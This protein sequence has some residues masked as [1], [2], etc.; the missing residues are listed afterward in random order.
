M[1]SIIRRITLIGTIF[2]SLS[3][4]GWPD[5]SAAVVSA[6]YTRSTPIKVAPGQIDI[7]PEW[8]RRWPNEGSSG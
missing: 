1:D 2:V 7:F 6:G 3:I 8:H 5:T 4:V